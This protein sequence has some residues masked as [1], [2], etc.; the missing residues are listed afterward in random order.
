MFTNVIVGVDN[1]DGGRDA[2]AL[3][4]QLLVG[5]GE[6]T[7]VHVYAGEPYVYRGVS[8]AYEASE[9]ERHLGLLASTRAETG[10]R[11]RLCWRNASSVK[12]GLHE[13]CE[14]L[15][16]DLLVLGSS[17]RGLFGRLL[18]GDDARATLSGAPCA[19]AIAPGGYQEKPFALREIGVG[20]DGSLESRHALDVASDLADAHGSNLSAFEAINVPDHPLAGRRASNQSSNAEIVRAARARIGELGEVQPYAVCGQPGDELIR[21]SATVDLL[22]IGSTGYGRIQTDIARHHS[23]AAGAQSPLSPARCDALCIPAGPR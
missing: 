5:Q 16:A 22:V 15:G 3:A 2:I 13:L 12:R 14:Q 23:A 17:R 20:F 19:V 11:A 4:G 6:L 18:F 9:R 7:L 8:A 10:V 21:F 1:R